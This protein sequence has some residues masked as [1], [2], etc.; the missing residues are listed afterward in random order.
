MTFTSL[1]VTVLIIMTLIMLGC[2]FRGYKKGL[3]KSL[4]GLCITLFSAIFGA[5]LSVFVVELSF[6]AVMDAVSDMAFYEEI[7][8]ILSDFES[9]IFVVIKML[10]SLVLYIP[11]FF[12]LKIVLGILASI[13][14]KCLCVK[15]NKSEVS[16]DK[17]NEEL[18]VKRNK[19][20]AALIGVLTG[21]VISIAVFA[22]AAGSVRVAS[23]IFEF[24]EE[25]AGEEFLE[26]E[27]EDAFDYLSDD[28]S[29]SLVCACGGDAIFD[30]ATTVRV[31]DDKTSLSKELEVIAEIDFKEFGELVK[32][33]GTAAENAARIKNIS[34]K[35]EKSKL[36]ELMFV[37]T[38]SGL[39]EAW[40]K[41]EEYIGV[42][43][44]TFD[45][46]KA[47]DSFID[48][49]LYVCKDTSSETI[50]ADV[51]TLINISSLL[52]EKERLLRGSYQQVISALV[53]GGIINNVRAELEKNLR[54]SSVV[55][56]LDNLMMSVIAE[57]I[58]DYTKYSEAE[59][60]EL[61]NEISS[62]LT[63]TAS[64]SGVTRVNAVASD[65]KQKFEGYGVYVP[66]SLH[67]D[68]AEKLIEDVDISDGDVTYDDVKDYFE[69][70]ISE[71]QDINDYL[72][73]Q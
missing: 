68:I 16:Y 33:K 49:L 46:T 42:A 43:R 65:I 69:E 50:S 24:A 15:Q 19:S 14:Y 58:Q 48:E 40:L 26:E 25:A 57:E 72:P 55:A 23:R 54:M 61:F 45:E 35:I 27:V 20:I 8:D 10:I 5:F 11:A 29:L 39:S 12:I 34:N 70:F 18:Y 71:G 9:V 52:M 22:P 73:Q 30:F 60:E 41:N 2:A 53:D 21:F 28:F 32:F 62:I 17:E 1:S 38:L 4:I 44:P 59:C 63:G 51:N 13:I 37:E 3:S 66:D 56:A 67:Q 36:L 6:D 64:L 47:V 31:E 7:A